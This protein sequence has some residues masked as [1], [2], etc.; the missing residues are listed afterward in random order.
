MGLVADLDGGKMD[1]D[2]GAIVQSSVGLFKLHTFH[3]YAGPVRVFLS[4]RSVYDPHIGLNR[5]PKLVAV[6]GVV[7]DHRRRL[8]KAAIVDA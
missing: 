4:P 7:D 8:N 3:R 2:V 5:Y 1:D 6:P